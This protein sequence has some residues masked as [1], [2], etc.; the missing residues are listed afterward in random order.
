[1]NCQN[2]KILDHGPN[3]ACNQYTIR[4]TPPFASPVKI[5]PPPKI[6]HEESESANDLVSKS[7]SGPCLS[8]LGATSVSPRRF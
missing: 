6:E 7:P 2:T 1:M 4:P 8:R 3:D 5:P